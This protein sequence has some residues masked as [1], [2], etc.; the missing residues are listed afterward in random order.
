VTLPQARQSSSVNVEI[1]KEKLKRYNYFGKSNTVKTETDLLPESAVFRIWL[2]DFSP[3]FL[4]YP[5]LV[6]VRRHLI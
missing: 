4:V 3:D 6:V 2:A 5:W 1:Q